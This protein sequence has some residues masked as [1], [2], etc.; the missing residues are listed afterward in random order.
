M[1]SFFFKRKYIYFVFNFY[2]IL[3]ISV[4]KYNNFRLKIIVFS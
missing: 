4:N 1:Y 3:L 2:A